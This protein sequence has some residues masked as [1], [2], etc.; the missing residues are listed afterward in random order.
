MKSV[1]SHGLMVF[2]ALALSALMP[3]MAI[4][5]DAKGVIMPDPGSGRAP[6]AAGDPDASGGGIAYEPPID[7]GL[8]LKLSLRMN[9]AVIV[10]QFG[11]MVLGFDLRPT[12]RSGRTRMDSLRR[13][14]GRK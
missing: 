12:L 13:V 2:L 11:S 6:Q 14:A 8:A 4:A 5:G 9:L 10:P 1:R 3:W 7:Y